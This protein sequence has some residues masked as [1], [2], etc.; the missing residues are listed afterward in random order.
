MSSDL[1]PGSSAEAG[2]LAA[3]PSVARRV[4]G[5]TRDSLVYGLGVAGQ[6]VI[7]LIL[8]PILTRVFAP[9]EYGAT[10]LIGLLLLFVSYFV[11]VGNDSALL[12]FVFDTDS[13]REQGAI[14]RAIAQRWA[15]G[16]PP[17]KA[18]PATGLALDFGPIP[19]S[20]D[21]SQPAG[22]GGRGRELP[23]DRRR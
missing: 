14:A 16:K 1:A 3:G 21:Q 2:A 19:P 12:R 4:K 7:G 13:E 8:L 18:P 5:L 9:A 17:A 22:T 23:G 20:P 10:E 11:V 6:K 15:R